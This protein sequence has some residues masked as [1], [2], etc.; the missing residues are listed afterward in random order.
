MFGILSS[1]ETRKGNRDNRLNDSDFLKIK[2][3]T[4]V[5]MRG[6]NCN[7]F[8]KLIEELAFPNRFPSQ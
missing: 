1:S 2:K 5:S 6:I 7:L 4:T 8:S 3:T